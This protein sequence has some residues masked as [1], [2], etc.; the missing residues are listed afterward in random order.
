MIRYAVKYEPDESGGYI[1]LVP[2]LG[3]EAVTQGDTL[4]EAREMA[5][6]LVSELLTSAILDHD[7]DVPWGDDE[8]PE[9]YEWVYPDQKVGVAAMIRAVRK[10]AGLSM[11]QAAQR[12]GV[13]KGAYQKWEHP[14][15]CNATIESLEKVAKGFQRRLVCEFV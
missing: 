3:T 11:D 8:K 9:D 7:K 12:C 15:K 2:S 5:A 1:A 10:V 6:D 13:T 4:E 14:L